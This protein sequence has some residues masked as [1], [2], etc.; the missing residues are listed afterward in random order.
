MRISDWSSDVC[1]SDLGIALEGGIVAPPRFQG[2]KDGAIA[3]A[4]IGA[5]EGS[6]DRLFL[7]AEYAGETQRAF[8]RKQVAMLPCALQ[9]EALA[10]AAAG[11]GRKRARRPRILPDEDVANSRKSGGEGK[12]G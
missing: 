1:S 12:R 3:L 4:G 11:A 8:G 7:G 2:Q 6:A 10:G 5:A 9:A